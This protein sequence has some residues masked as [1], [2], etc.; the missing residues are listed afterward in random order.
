MMKV[1]ETLKY[2][3]PEVI[4]AENDIAAIKVNLG[5]ATMFTEYSNGVFTFQPK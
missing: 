1:N 5:L 2:I 3:L 4:D